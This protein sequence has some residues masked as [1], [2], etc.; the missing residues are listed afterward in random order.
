[1]CTSVCDFYYF[2]FSRYLS[3]VFEITSVCSDSSNFEGIP[4]LGT[5]YMR[6]LAYLTETIYG[7]PRAVSLPVVEERHRQCDGAVDMGLTDSNVRQA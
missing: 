5:S 6:A 4:G 2:L 7:K 1:M 3:V